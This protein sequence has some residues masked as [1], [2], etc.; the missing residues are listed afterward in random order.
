MPKTSV[1]NSTTEKFS[2]EDILAVIDDN[3]QQKRYFTIKLTFP[4]DKKK[5][6]IAWMR[7][8]KQ[9][10]VDEVLAKVEGV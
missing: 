6:V 8:N 9:S 3:Y 5:Q 2:M 10:L 1:E 7:K 4:M